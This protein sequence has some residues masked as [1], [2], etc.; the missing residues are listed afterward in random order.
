MQETQQNPNVPPQTPAPKPPPGH[1]FSSSEAIK[2]GFN[3]FKKNI[4][5]FI[6]LGAALIVINIVMGIIGGL[7]GHNNLIAL[8]WS[9]VSAILSLIIQ[10][11]I[12]KIVLDLHDGKPLNLANLYSMFHLAPRFIGASVLYGL[13]ILVGLVLLI[14]PG[15]Y[16]AIKL[17]FY[18]F[19][20]V[21][22][23]AGVVDSLKKSWAIT[24]GVEL[25]LFLFTLVIVILNILGAIALL[26][27]LLVTIPTTTMASV[28]V[29]RKL[30]SQTPGV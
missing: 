12:I 22:K 14:I 4:A 9:I 15:I 7:F 17:Q 26:V 3:F 5:T 27:G 2:F 29:Y 21:D 23:N 16:L 24:K 8:I 13:M 20:I 11:G 1:S 10:V 28:Y 6:K 30:L 19:L 25:N 18:S